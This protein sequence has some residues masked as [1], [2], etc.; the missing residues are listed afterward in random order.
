M[1]VQYDTCNCG[2]FVALFAGHAIGRRK[3]STINMQAVEELRAA[4]CRGAWGIPHWM[5][6]EEPGSRMTRTCCGT[7]AP[8][9]KTEEVRRLM[10]PHL[11]GLSAWET[12]RISVR[13][14]VPCY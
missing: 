8:G 7:R 12:Y 5:A 1:L 13:L 4:V 9:I 10:Q 2:L 11:R 14:A 6:L 3:L